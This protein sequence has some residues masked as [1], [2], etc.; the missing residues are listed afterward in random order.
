MSRPVFMCWVCREARLGRERIGEMK[1]SFITLHYWRG[2]G[3]CNLRHVARGRIES[4]F[5]LLLSLLLHDGL[6]V[7]FQEFN[8]HGGSFDL[9]LLKGWARRLVAPSPTA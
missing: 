3:F 7:L 5:T 4:S 8:V 9:E 6:A 2:A 1:G